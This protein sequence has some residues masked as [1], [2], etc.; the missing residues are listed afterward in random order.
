M[1]PVAPL[2]AHRDV[3]GGSLQVR[4]GQLGRRAI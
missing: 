1:Q 4:L 2:Q 3:A